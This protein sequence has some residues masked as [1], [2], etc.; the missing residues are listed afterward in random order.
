MSTALLPPP[1]AG[2]GQR[3]GAAADQEAP[4]LRVV[5]LTAAATFGLPPSRAPKPPLLP[6]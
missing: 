5:S 1:L 3:E 2:G 4:P 6:P